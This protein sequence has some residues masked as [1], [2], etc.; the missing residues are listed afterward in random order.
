MEGEYELRHNSSPVKLPDENPHGE[1]RSIERDEADL[2]RLGKKPV[3]KVSCGA[4]FDR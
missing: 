2:M 3:L 4:S 1:M